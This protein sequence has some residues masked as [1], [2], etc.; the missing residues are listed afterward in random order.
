MTS[1]WFDTGDFLRALAPP[2]PDVDIKLATVQSVLYGTGLRVIFDGETVDS[3]KYY[4]FATSYTP[5]VG[6]RVKMQR[7]GKTY[8]AEYSVGSIPKI[9]RVVLAADFGNATVTFQ[10]VTGMS[11][12]VEAGKQ[13][14]ILCHYLYL[15]TT[16]QDI[17]MR[18]TYPA[19]SNWDWG[20]HHLD[21]GVAA[22]PGAFNAEGSQD[23]GTATSGGFFFGGTGAKVEAIALSTLTAGAAGTLQLQMAQ[24]VGGSSSFVLHGSYIISVES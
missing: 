15:A 12:T 8:V 14:S 7:I 23:D 9:Q 19:A 22:N 11:L 3:G 6:D 1:S 16:G 13:Y 17:I 24:V 21:S 2:A 10:N 5:R 4:K 20:T 18:W